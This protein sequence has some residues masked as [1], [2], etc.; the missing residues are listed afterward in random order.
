MTVRRARFTLFSSASIFAVSVVAGAWTILAANPFSAT[1]YP[2]EQDLF[3]AE[4]T[5]AETIESTEYGYVEVVEGCGPS[6][7]GECL[8]VRSGPGEEYRSLGRLRIG[9]VLKVEPV[10]TAMQTW[11]RVLFDEALRYPERVVHGQYVSAKHVRHFYGKGVE[12]LNNNHATSTKRIVVDRSEQK[13]YAYEDDVSFMEVAV[14]TGIELTPTPRGTFTI[15]KK[16]PTR[17]MQ[18]PLPGISKK[19][20]DLPGVPWNLYFTKEGAVI[21]G[22]Y[23]HDEFG[24]RWSNGCVNLFPEDARKLYEWADIGTEV[25]VRD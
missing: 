8:L 3:G 16:T 2:L 25:L 19:S 11:Y 15:Y 6:F 7:D 23:W 20:Y 21:H 1:P 13:L 17:Y 4:I 24:R 9:V 22:T 18:G 12:E 14:S 10:F 5:F